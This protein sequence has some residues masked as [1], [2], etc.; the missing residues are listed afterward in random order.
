MQ[1]VNYLVKDSL[2]NYLS[3][4]PIPDTLIG[5]FRLLFNSRKIFK[6]LYLSVATHVVKSGGICQQLRSFIVHE[7]TLWILWAIIERVY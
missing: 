3:S 2:P 1:L 7:P 6:K 4:L 5:I